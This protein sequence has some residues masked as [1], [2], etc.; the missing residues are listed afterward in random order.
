MLLYTS[1]GDNIASPYQ[2]TLLYNKFS[3][4]TIIHVGGVYHASRNDVS[5]SITDASFHPLVPTHYQTI[6]ELTSFINQT[7]DQTILQHSFLPRLRNILL[8]AAGIFL[9]VC[10]GCGVLIAPKYAPSISYGIPSP[11]TPEKKGKLFGILVLSWVC[12]LI[13]CPILWIFCK[14][15]DSP[16]FL[17]LAFT[18]LCLLGCIILFSKLFGISVLHRFKP[19]KISWKRTLFCSGL[20]IGLILLMLF[21]LWLFYP[22]TVSGYASNATALLICVADLPV[23]KAG[24]AT[25]TE[26]QSPA[27]CCLV[28]CF[29][30]TDDFPASGILHLAWKHC[31]LLL[32]GLRRDAG[33]AFPFD[34]NF[35]RAQ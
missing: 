15:A 18:L 22:W 30:V 1:N 17:T 27:A 23:F 3:T 24:G 9:F 20:E 7:T 35:D 5:L 6:Y 14:N 13:A 26:G 4:D 28:R 19:L 8:F 21:Y 33:T 16:L 29:S 25:E 12:A 32:S 34:E 11:F 2:M 31:C 10:L